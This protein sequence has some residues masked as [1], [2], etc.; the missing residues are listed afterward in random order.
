MGDGWETMGEN[1]E[2]EEKSEGWEKSKFG[3]EP[4]CRGQIG[5]L[6]CLLLSGISGILSLSPR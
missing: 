2:D 3:E 5:G 4:G 1:G 6:T